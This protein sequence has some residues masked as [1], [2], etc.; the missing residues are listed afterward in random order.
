MAKQIMRMAI[1]MH[2]GSPYKTGKRIKVIG[3]ETLDK[4]VINYELF[5]NKTNQRVQCKT[6]ALSNTIEFEINKKDKA[7][8]LWNEAI[9][10]IKNFEE[11]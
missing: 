9:S 3:N 8:E 6:G 1:N 7:N 10:K 4:V 11:I 5:D 2:S